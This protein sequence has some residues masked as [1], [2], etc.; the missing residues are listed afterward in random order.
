MFPSVP[1]FGQSKEAP[2]PLKERDGVIVETCTHDALVH[3]G[4]VL[5]APFYRR[6]TAIHNPT[7][8]VTHIASLETPGAPLF[9]PRRWRG[10]GKRRPY[11]DWGAPMTRRGCPT[12]QK[13]TARAAGTLAVQTDALDIGLESMWS[14]HKR[15][16]PRPSR[17]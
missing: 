8:W 17:S 5:G 2:R 14:Q 12:T 9:Q 10:V 6:D 3:L 16:Q 11:P 15:N 7:R 13:L 4:Q 1:N